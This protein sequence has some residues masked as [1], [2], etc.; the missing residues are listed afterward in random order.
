M[1]TRPEDSALVVL[2]TLPDAERARALVRQLVER[3]LIAC[4][5]VL[6]PVTSIYR[7]RGAI[8]ESS[9]VQV[10]FKTRRDRWPALEEAVR[11]LHPYEVPE[12]LAVP[13]ERGLGAYLAWLV[14]ETEI[15]GEAAV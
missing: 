1:V 2:T 4:G 3:R 12:L 8:E 11:E 9:E 10:L 14:E 6:G 15:P 13:V 7:W 5:T